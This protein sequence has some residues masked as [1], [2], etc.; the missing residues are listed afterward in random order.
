M[1][2]HRSDPSV[3]HDPETQRVITHIATLAAPFLQVLGPGVAPTTLQA[4]LLAAVKSLPITE[5]QAPFESLQYAVQCAWLAAWL[6]SLAARA[7]QLRR[8]C[9]RPTWKDAGTATPDL[10]LEHC[11]L[12]DAQGNRT[13]YDLETQLQCCE[14]Y[15][16]ASPPFEQTCRELGMS[17]TEKEAVEFVHELRYLVCS[18]LRHYR[19]LEFTLPTLSAADRAAGK[20]SG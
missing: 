20:P 10:L 17:L 8:V 13:Q 15:E 9:F 14:E 2:E 19:E 3:P 6:R 4:A 7:P 12:E 1:T 16:R 11:V 5:Q 18:Y